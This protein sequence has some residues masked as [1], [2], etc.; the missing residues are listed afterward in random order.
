MPS[1][2]FNTLHDYWSANTFLGHSDFQRTM[3]QDDFMR[4]CMSLV[5]QSQETVTMEEKQQVL[6]WHCRDFMAVI[7]QNFANIAI[8]IGVAAIYERTATT[9]ACC[10]AQ[11]YM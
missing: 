3:S 1:V 4:I 10:K 11:M 8:P 7:F 6:L 2:G 9:K 5:F